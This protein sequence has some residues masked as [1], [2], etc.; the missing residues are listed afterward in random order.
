MI[1][2]WQGTQWNSHT[3]FMIRKDCMEGRASCT[4][5][6]G[7][8]YA[9]FNLTQTAATAQVCCVPRELLKSH[10]MPLLAPA[11][12]VANLLQV[13]FPSYEMFLQ[14]KVQRAPAWVG[15]KSSSPP[16]CPENTVL[17]YRQT[18]VREAS[19]SL[20][21]SCHFDKY[22]KELFNIFFYFLYF[23]FLFFWF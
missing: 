21:I 19:V 8:L 10:V 11:F 15:V 18:E 9:W 6:P 14:N 12:T 16:C 20:H 1:N 7:P 22:I 2:C 4:W 17:G 5:L 3:C 23:L 13:C